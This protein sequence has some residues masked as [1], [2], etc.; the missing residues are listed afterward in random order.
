LFKVIELDRLDANRKS[1]ICNFLL[2]INSDCDYLNLVF[3]EIST[4]GAIEKYSSF[5]SPPLF[6]VPAQGN[7]PE[8]LNETYAARTGGILYGAKLHNLHQPFLI[9]PPV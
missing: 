1:I 3:F 8:F 6:D 5:P 4:H 9:D 2:I 7:P